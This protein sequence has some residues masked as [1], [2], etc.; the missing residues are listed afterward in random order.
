MITVQPARTRSPTTGWPTPNEP[1][2][3]EASYAPFAIDGNRAVAVG[4]SRYDDARGKRVYHNAF[5]LEFDDSGACRSFRDYY[6]L[7][8]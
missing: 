8:P 3:Y 2:T 7:E 6:I 5:V 1:G 4:T